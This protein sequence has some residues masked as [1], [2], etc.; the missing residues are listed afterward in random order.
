MLKK[1]DHFGG[2]KGP[3]VTVVLDGIGLGAQNEGNAIHLARTPVLDMLMKKYPNVAINAHGTSV[4]LPSDGD[5]GNSEVGHN[6]IGSGQVVSQ[7]AK[8]VNN[9][10]AT[11]SLFQGKVWNDAVNRVKES[12]STLHFIGLFSDGNIHSHN[13]H[14]KA[15]IL[16][17]KEQNVAKVRV[18]PL[19]DG[20]DVPA[21]SALDYVEPFEK[22]MEELSNDGFDI[23]FASSGG[24]MKITMDRY[25][26]DWPMVEAGW[27]V[28]VLGEGR[29]FESVSEAV[30]TLRDELDV[31]DQNLPGFVI[32]KKGEPV[33]KIE[34][35]DSVIFTNFR[36]DRSI[37]ISRAFAEENFSEFDRVRFPKVFYAGMMQYD[38]DDQIPA[39]FLVDP[40]AISNTLG[41]TLVEQNMKQLAISETQKYGHVT[42]FWNGNRSGKFDDKNESYVEI[43]SDNVPFEQRPWM[44][45]AE[46]TDE[47]I[48][49]LQTG[50]F[51]YARVNYANGDMVGHTGDLNAAIVSV[52]A[53][54]ICLG[55]LLPA[56]D[57]LGGMAIITADHGNADE[58]F[59]V[60]KGKFQT[61][62]DGNY[63]PKTSHTLNQVPCIFYDNQHQGDYK[64][65]PEVSKPG[66]GNL[67]A[68]NLNLMGLEA[69]EQYEKSLIIPA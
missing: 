13:E 61:D 1:L 27:K 17:A 18:H 63:V 57:A 41:Q 24:R 3:I 65:N 5:M 8:L 40:P 42:F 68:T 32:A 33:G 45:A 54:D 26:A 56:I 19:L 28:H 46:I 52:E 7:G 12:N 62:A 30:K 43:P 21:R 9:A 59:Q 14:L 23:C 64:L 47:M 35:N 53:V 67:A 66:I 60:K 16:K 29:Q 39:N 48:K 6:A 10:I 25:D 49:Q 69:P 58:M 50:S 22:W 15:M 55:R 44:K 36:G 31:D 4:G 11:G 38:G 20:R 51:D 34:D 2:Y 37:E